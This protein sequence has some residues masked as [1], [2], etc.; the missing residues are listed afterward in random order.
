[1][2]KD[3]G[4]SSKNINW[5]EVPS[6]G[7]SKML[8]A[9]GYVAIILEVED[10][11]SK[12]RL[13]FTYD[14]DEG[15]YKGFF[16]DDDRAYTHQFKRWYTEKSMGYMSRFLECIEKSN[17]DFTL[18]GWDNNLNDLVGKRI[19]I[20]V[21]REDYTNQSGEDR[22]RMNVEDYATIEDIRL[23]R[24]K[25]PDP[26]DNRTGGGKPPQAVQQGAS[27]GTSAYDADIPF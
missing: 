10:I 7:V 9:G 11:E 2:E 15:E 24:Y 12:E 4:F 23:G 26:K 5:S 3:M 25:I 21:Q 13:D 27:G 16:A 17:P 14:I 6:V 19:G 1:M 18:K 8:P 22:A 20:I